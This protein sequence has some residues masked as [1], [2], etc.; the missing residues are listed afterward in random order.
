MENKVYSF[1]LIFTSI[2][3]MY[4]LEIDGDSSFKDVVEFAEGELGIHSNNLKFIIGEG[5]ELKVTREVT[6]IHKDD[7]LYTHQVYMKGKG[8]GWIDGA[9][10]SITIEKRDW[11]AGMLY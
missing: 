11:G 3:R 5:V 7:Y 6:E 2:N 4:K 1:K 8:I 10:A 9:V